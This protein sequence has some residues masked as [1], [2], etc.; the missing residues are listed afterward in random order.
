MNRNMNRQH[1]LH[2]GKDHK[3]K[4]RCSII[5]EFN[6][7]VLSEMQKFCHYMIELSRDYGVEPRCLSPWKQVFLDT[8]WVIFSSMFPAKL[9]EKECF[10]GENSLSHFPIGHINQTGLSKSV[11]RYPYPDPDPDPDPNSGSDVSPC[12]ELIRVNTVSPLYRRSSSPFRQHENKYVPFIRLS[13]LW[14]ESYGF[15]IGKKYEIYAMKNQLILRTSSCGSGCSCE[16]VNHISPFPIPGY[17]GSRDRDRDREG[18][19]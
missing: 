12:P 10:L 2:E 11:I 16:L 15:E 3:N 6:G 17:D 1:E 7:Q 13:G 4:K 5:G 8:I 14:L 19:R 18:K 9:Q